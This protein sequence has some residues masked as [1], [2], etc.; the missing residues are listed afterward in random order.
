M[1]QSRKQN[2]EKKLFKIGVVGPYPPNIGG[3]ASFLSRLVPKLE[4]QGFYCIVFNTQKGNPGTGIA[5]RISRFFFFSQ[6]SL[7]VLFSG[8]EIIHC[9]AVNWANLIGNMLVIG[10]NRP[11]RKTILT[12]HAGDLLSKMAHKR[13]QGI[14]SFL[15]KI[16]DVITTVTPELCDE[17]L[18][19]GAKKVIFIPNELSYANDLHEPIPEY[20]RQF[21]VEHRPLI[22]A[23]GA[24]ERVHGMDLLIRAASILR[25]SFP[26]LGVIIVAYKS[27]NAAY[28]LEIDRIMSDLDLIDSIIFPSV[29]PDVQAVMKLAGVVVRPTLSDGDSIAIREALSLGVPVVASD[30]GHRPEGVVQFRSGD[31]MQ[32][33]ARINEVLSASNQSKVTYKDN[34]ENTMLEYMRAYSMA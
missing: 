20:L 6:L 10:M 30:V 32:L 22:V 34:G 12:L 8:C 7:K 29:L 27:V 23:V 1:K 17:A 2:P 18:R 13:T 16:P 31:Y 5:E 25:K 9:H 3:T 15:M 14:A 4:E 33:A 28:K 11:F 26:S 21:T 24:M 19:L